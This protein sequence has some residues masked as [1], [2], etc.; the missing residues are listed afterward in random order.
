MRSSGTEYVTSSPGSPQSKGRVEKAVK[1]AKSLIK[2]AKA[3]GADYFLSLLSWRNTPK[4]GLN[5]SP[6]SAYVWATYASP[7]VKDET[8][9]EIPCDKS[10]TWFKAAIEE[11]ADVP[12]YKVKTEDGESS[13]E[14][15]DIILQEQAAIL[16]LTT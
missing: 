12:S 13:A 10:Q 3:S 6:G 9:R 2:K 4:E 7:L 15:V 5:T 14:T 1:T 11:L 8:V 16:Q